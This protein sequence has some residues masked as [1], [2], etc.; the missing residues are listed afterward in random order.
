M[1]VLINYM[2]R[3]LLQCVGISNHHGICT[4][5]ISYNFTCQLCLHQA[6]KEETKGYYFFN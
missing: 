1:D 5:E 2:E 6:E 4:L 3:I